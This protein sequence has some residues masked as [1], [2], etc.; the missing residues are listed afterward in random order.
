MARQTHIP[1]HADLTENLEAGLFAVR[2][3]EYIH[4]KTRDAL[5]AR[6]YVK[7][8]KS[9]EIRLTAKGERAARG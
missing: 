9:G 7:V 3:G 4:H 1:K 8:L 6:N 5:A 2:D